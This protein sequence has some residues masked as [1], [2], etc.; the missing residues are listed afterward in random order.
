MEMFTY[1]HATVLQIQIPN[2]VWWELERR[3]LLIFLGKTHSSSVVHERV[4]AGLEREGA[5]SHLP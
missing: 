2:A 1:P 4:I 5:T 3:L